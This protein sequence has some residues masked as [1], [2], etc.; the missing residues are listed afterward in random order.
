MLLWM[1]IAATGLAWLATLVLLL[2]MQRRVRAL[3]A[4]ASLA[5]ALPPDGSARPLITVEIL[6]PFELAT[7][8][9]AVAA[10]GARLAPRVIERIVYQQTS[11]ILRTEIAKH[12]VEARVRICHVD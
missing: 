4:R 8:R 7:Q 1:L 2:R 11:S 5:A 12:G 6:N 9:V 10:I 3:H